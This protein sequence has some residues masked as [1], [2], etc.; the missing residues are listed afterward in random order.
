MKFKVGFSKHVLTKPEKLE[1]ILLD[2][3]PYTIFFDDQEKKR[4]IELNNLYFLFCASKA[5]Q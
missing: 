2:K 3:D 5:F 1:K 4:R